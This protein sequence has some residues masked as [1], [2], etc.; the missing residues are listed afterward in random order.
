MYEQICWFKLEVIKLLAFQHFLLG[1][2][3]LCCGPSGT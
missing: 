2:T 3:T 1:H